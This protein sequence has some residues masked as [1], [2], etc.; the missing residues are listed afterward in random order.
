MKNTKHSFIVNNMC[1]LIKDNPKITL[2]QLSEILKLNSTYLQKLFSKIT[3]LSP[4]EYALCV[5]ENSF[6]NLLDTEMSITQAIYQSGHESNSRIYEKSNELLGMT[7]KEYKN[8]QYEKDIMLAVGECSLGSFLIAQT[9]KGICAISLGNNPQ[10][11]IEEIQTR[12]KKANFIAGNNIFED[13]VAKVIGLIEN[14]Q[15]NIDLPLDIRGTMF[16]Q[17]VYKT[18]KNIPVGTTVSY[19]QLAEMVGSPKAVRA[20]ANACANNKI[21]CLIPCHRVV[22]SNG[23]LAGYRW[24]IE[25]KEKLL[26]KEKNI[27][28]AIV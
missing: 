25:I 7:P 12:F 18:L 3:G 26:Q 11:L 17:K 22:R 15:N 16:Q 27:E 6:K 2:E 20:V 24:G 1:L 21:A 14:P 10:Q 4:K 23:N 9:D 19:K 13:T 5:Q 8:G 28:E